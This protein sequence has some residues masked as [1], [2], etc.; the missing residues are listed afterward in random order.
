MV[1][2][3]LKLMAKLARLLVLMA[4]VLITR[5]WVFVTALWTIIYFVMASPQVSQLINRSMD[6]VIPGSM[7]MGR[8]Q[9]SINP[10][11]LDIWDVNFSRPNHERVIHV[12]HLKVRLNPVPLILF[13]TGTKKRLALSFDRIILDG[14][15]VLLPF[16]KDNKFVFTETFVRHKKNKNR[17]A[18]S[19]KKRPGPL[20]DFRNVIAHKGR[21]TLKLGSW[22]L[23]LQGL[24]FVTNLIVDIGYSH[25]LFKMDVRNLT[26]TKG[27]SSIAIC[28]LGPKACNHQI[29]GMK[30]R[31]FQMRGSA[32][33]FKGFNMDIPK[34][35][36]QATGTMSFPKS[37]GIK[38]RGKASI[39]L[40]DPDYLRDLSLGIVSGPV[41]I[42]AGGEGTKY[43]PTFFATVKSS[44]LNVLGLDGPKVFYGQVIGV[45]PGPGDYNFI[46][47]KA[48]LKEGETTITLRSLKLS[49]FV[50]GLVRQADISFKNLSSE[51]L[52]LAPG[53]LALPGG[54]TGSLHI[55]PLAKGNRR[56]YLD[57]KTRFTRPGLFA[58]GPMNLVLRAQLDP[59]LSRLKVKRLHL[60]GPVDNILF[61]GIVGPGDGRLKGKLDMDWDIRGISDLLKQHVTGTLHSQGMTVKGSISSPILQGPVNSDNLAVPKARPFTI[62]GNCR[63]SVRGLDC[64][65]LRMIGNRSLFIGQGF[66]LDDWRRFRLKTGKGV[67]DLSLLHQGI[68]G[69]ISMNL[70]NLRFLVSSLQKSL[71]G[72]LKIRSGMIRTK[73][74]AF[75]NLKGHLSANKGNV[76]V[77]SFIFGMGGGNVSFVGKFGKNISSIKGKLLIRGCDLSEIGLCK[78]DC[79]GIFSGRLVL[80]MNKRNYLPSGKFSIL[81]AGWGNVDLGNISMMVSPG[82]NGFINLRGSAMNS[83]LNLLSGSGLKMKG[84]TLRRIVLQG[85]LHGVDIGAF[86]GD[87]WPK[88]LKT[89]ISARMNLAY[90]MNS[91]NFTGRINVPKKGLKISFTP[92]GQNLY[93]SGFSLHFQR[94]AFYSENL[95]INDGT[96]VVKLNMTGSQDFK[97]L[98]LDVKGYLGMY[99]LRY[100]KDTIM[101]TMGYLGL[102][103][104]ITRTLSGYVMRGT[105]IT[106]KSSI[107][108]KG[109]ADVIHLQP[110]SRI[111]FH[112]TGGRTQLQVKEGHRLKA[113]VGN[114]NVSLWGSALLR[115]GNLVRSQ[116][117]MDGVNLRVTSQGFLWMNLTPKLDLTVSGGQSSLSGIINITEG[118]FDK[119]YSKFMGLSYQSSSTSLTDRFP[120]LSATRLKLRIKGK[121]FKVHSKFP[122]GKTDMTLSM[123]LNL[124]GSLGAPMVYNRIEVVPGSTV[125]YNLVTRRFEVARG[126]FQFNGPLEHPNIDIQAQTKVKYHRKGRQSSVVQSRFIAETLEMNNLRNESEIN[127]NLLVKGVFPKLSVT[128]DSNARDLDQVDLEYL[129]LTGMT[130]QDIGSGQGSLNVG[131]LTEGISGVLAKAMMTPII[132]VASIGIQPNGGFTADVSLK[133]GHNLSLMTSVEQNSTFAGYSAGFQF[134]LTENLTL[135]GFVRSVEMS[136]DPSEVGRRYESKLRYRIPLE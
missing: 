44:G 124:R 9:P 19:G 15:D 86:V 82:H 2:H 115:N 77:N 93:S 4:Y 136:P 108:V 129:L 78:G 107:A 20:L 22:T 118:S 101:D 28:P 112:N 109:F 29:D 58:S 113:Q 60:R 12:D 67:L 135:E 133:L 87:S 121:N 100:F 92:A 62:K 34:G 47:S 99:F 46:L 6:I 52:R 55:K 103:L 26:A 119:D 53:W 132:D 81:D 21:A 79:R 48:G 41:V 114:G 111:T 122:L 35:K 16:D 131:M 43:N 126:I 31:R 110:N 98:Q 30:V 40:D 76:T 32:L 73:G 66:A 80:D 123:D 24:D 89:N 105:A 38:Y 117:H 94:K 39:M 5:T 13:L 8:I 1:I 25:T 14:F 63:V 56:I 120:W 68:S 65:E 59:G 51:Y 95:A 102:N 71:D 36:I 125:F 128:L 90:N 83:A 74:L 84:K 85:S 64:S 50:K 130:K 54:Y 72:N 97:K 134:R 3:I 116:M 75:S 18:Q 45:K 42:R 27:S 37:V 7:T 10:T 104:R 49:P 106:G 91:N 23:K 17:H 11:N 69:R 57:L 127:V 96:K 61:N 88:D 33:S 70:K